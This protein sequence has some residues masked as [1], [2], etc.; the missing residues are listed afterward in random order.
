MNYNY[1]YRL[2]PTKQQ[3][4]KLESDLDICRKLYNFFLAHLN[5]KEDNPS[6]TSQQNMLPDMKKYFTELRKPYSKV[7]QMVV[8]RLHSN[9]SSLSGQKKNGRKVGSLRYK[10]K[11]WYKTFT[12]NQ[13]GF[14]VTENDGWLD[15]LDLS[16][17]GEIPIC[18]HRE[19][20]RDQYDIKQVKVK[21]EGS[22][23]WFAILCLEDKDEVEV[24]RN[25]PDLSDV[26][27]DDC[28]GI[29]LGITKH[30]HDSDGN[31]VELL[32]VKD[33]RHKIRREHR[34]LSRKEVG[35]ENWKKQVKELNKAYKELSRARRDYLH[36]LSTWY[37]ENYD[38]ICVEDLDVKDMMMQSSNSRNKANASW[39][40][41]VRML[42]HKAESAGVHLI[43][44][45]PRGTTKECSSCG[46][47]TDK[48]LWVR[49]H[50]CPSCGYTAD[51]DENASY[52]ILQRGLDE[53]ELGPGGS[54]VKPLEI[55]ASEETT[56]V[57]ACRVV[58]QGSPTLNEAKAK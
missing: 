47:E 17:V 37:V 2:Y 26:C 23:E 39:G 10:G 38:L 13:S 43:K 11:G 25:K 34:K 22:G 6:Q 50:C 16:F 56:V 45:D 49:E 44:V 30:V 51:R 20:P 33:Q 54:D 29:D 36:K 12:Y 35:S 3:E 5:S 48:P 42:E 28:V 15:K 55:T 40:A 41:F 7:L 9:L 24:K 27:L 19:I 21:R 1:K 53:L 57:S 4:K 31:K 46:V 32:D 14:E 18:I 8:D 58:E 52:N